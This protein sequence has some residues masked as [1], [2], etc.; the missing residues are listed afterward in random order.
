M[1]CLLLPVNTVSPSALTALLPCV[2]ALLFFVI[3]KG[4][5]NWSLSADFSS[6]NG[7]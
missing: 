6:L 2:N 7:F 3:T 4:C 5:L 1:L